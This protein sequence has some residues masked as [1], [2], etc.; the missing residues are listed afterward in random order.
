VHFCASR[1]LSPDEARRL[2][3]L[4]FLEPTV[5][6]IPGELLLARVRE[7]LDTRLGATLR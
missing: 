1:G 5:E 2:I 7:A 4:G 6:Q 3:V